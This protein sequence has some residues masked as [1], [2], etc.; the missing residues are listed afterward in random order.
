MS[1]AELFVILHFQKQQFTNLPGDFLQSDHN[2]PLDQTSDDE[3]Y[4]PDSAPSLSSDSDDSI[5]NIIHRSK[6]KRFISD[7]TGSFKRDKSNPNADVTWLK[8]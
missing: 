7:T 8:L 4:V 2:S 5:P 3:L 6:V 1:H